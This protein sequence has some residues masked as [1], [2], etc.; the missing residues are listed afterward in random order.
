MNEILLHIN[1][2]SISSV[3][4]HKKLVGNVSF[5]IRRGEAFTLIGETGC[6]KTLVAQSITGAL[7]DELSASGSVTFEGLNLIELSATEKRKLWGKKLFL[8]P[9][10]A[11]NSLNPT[12]RALQQVAEVFRYLKGQRPGDAVKNAEKCITDLGL[13]PSRD[14]IHYP[15]RLS[16][17]MSQ[18]VLLAIALATPAEF[19]VADEPTK[20]LDTNLRD[21][22]VKLLKTLVQK[23]KTLLC[24]THDLTVAR[25]LGGTIAVMY[26]GYIVESGPAERVLDFPEHP[27]TRG[28]IKAAPEHG[29][30]PI[31]DHVL[32]AMD[33][34]W[35]NGDSQKSEACS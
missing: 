16:G 17:G 22:A 33:T 34:A 25:N 6:G 5:S 31:P 21:S 28:L 20:G 18:R 8:L 27:Y 4:E 2:L 10:E 7:P 24:I 3:A 11:K 26:G 14:T 9:Q 19:I 12:M 35:N 32:R 13:S 30:E 29:L 15:S 23:G 1:N